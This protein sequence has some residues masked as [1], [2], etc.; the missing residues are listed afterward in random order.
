MKILT[1]GQAGVPGFVKD[2]EPGVWDLDLILN[3]RNVERTAQLSI[4]LLSTLP[5]EINCL[6]CRS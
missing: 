2:M 4:G 5:Q 1:A 3:N 6:I